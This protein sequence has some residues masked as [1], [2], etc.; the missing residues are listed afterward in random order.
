MN[1]LTES[2]LDRYKFWSDIVRNDAQNVFHVLLKELQKILLRKSVDKYSI[3]P[4]K[5]YNSSF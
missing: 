5:V 4:N 2:I 1:N 3:F